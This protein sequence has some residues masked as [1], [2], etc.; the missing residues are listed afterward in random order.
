[1]TVVPGG[2]DPARTRAT[3]F[4]AALG[5]RLL[6]LIVASAILVVLSPLI[7]LFAV[8]IKVKSP[9]PVLYRGTRVGRHNTPFHLLKFRTMVVD[10]DKRGP[11]STADDDPRITP[12]G[13]FLRRHKLDEL[14]QL[15]NVLR[16]EMSL[17]GPRPQVQWAV[18]LY[19]PSERLLLSVRPG[20]TDFASLRFRDENLILRGST[21]PDGDYLRLIAPEK[22]RLGLAYVHRQSFA[23]DLVILAATAALM[24]GIGPEWCL[25]STTKG[26]AA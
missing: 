25:P 14:P 3:T 17:V 22:I 2:V 5:K 12:I 26:S 8:L 4:Y 6:D 11:S 9:G 13:H 20:I 18:D 15:L 10:A 23:T 1:M 21:D 24:F 19:Q 7:M 16:G